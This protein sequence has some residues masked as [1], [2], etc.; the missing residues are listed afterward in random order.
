MSL[1]RVLANARID[2][3]VAQAKGTQNR[4]E[5]LRARVDKARQKLV[6]LEASKQEVEKELATLRKAVEKAKGKLDSATATTEE[7]SSKVDEVREKSRQTSK[8][9]DK[10]LRSIAGWN[11]EIV[12]SGSDRHAI[13]KRCRLEEID[14]PLS[15]GRL[16]RV[17]L[18]ADTVAEDDDGPATANDYGIEPDF[19]ELQPEDLEVSTRCT[20]LTTEWRGRGRS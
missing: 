13:Y 2:F 10:A 20:L 14:L 19:D 5:T 3:E 6:Q 11:D 8:A 16:D 18:E 4:I 15:R 1:R 17:P 7:A 9:L 12:K